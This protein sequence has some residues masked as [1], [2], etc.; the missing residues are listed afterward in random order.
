[1]AKK[2]PRY[3]VLVLGGLGNGQIAQASIVT[4]KELGDAFG[5]KPAEVEKLVASKD[6]E[7]VAESTGEPEPGGVNVAE[8]PA[9]PEKPR[10]DE[11]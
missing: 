6:L 9:V 8:A 1:M 2:E 5:L 4:A 3:R 11:K 7:M 10:K